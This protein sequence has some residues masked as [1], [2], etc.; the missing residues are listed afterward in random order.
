MERKKSVEAHVGK[1][2]Y[3]RPT[4]QVIAVELEQGIAAGSG[5]SGTSSDV[6]KV[7]DNEES[8][9]QSTSANWF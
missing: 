1:L 6:Q 9:T 4:I 8:Q 3:Q 2:S 5:A 7:W